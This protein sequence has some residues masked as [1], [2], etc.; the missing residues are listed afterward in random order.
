MATAWPGG[1][2]MAWLSTWMWAPGYAILLVWLP[3]LFPTGRLPSR[4]WRPVAW[5][6]GVALVGII[7][8]IAIVTWPLRGLRLLADQPPATRSVQ[9]ALV[10]AGVMAVVLV[11]VGVAAVVSLVVRLRRVGTVERQQI[12]WYA[13]ASVLSVV[14]VAVSG[15]VPALVWLELLAA[16][17]V[18][19][20]LV[21]A[22]F[23]YRL[24]DIDWIISRTLVYGLLTAVLAGV[25]VTGCSL[26]AGCSTRPPVTRPWPWPPPPWPGCSSRCGGASSAWSTP[27]QPIPLR[28]GQ[29]RGGLQRPATGGDRPGQPLG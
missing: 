3:L 9:V 24:Y 5:L 11:G 18:I 1:P 12:K 27:L 2:L 23:R 7:A 16:P 25:Y 22:L 4:R 17:C 19:A 14:I 26:A 20:G 15:V 29:D 10:I 28:R 21:M 8:P 13:Y 6:A